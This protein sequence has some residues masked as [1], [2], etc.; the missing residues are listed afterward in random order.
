MH[1]P[2][3]LAI[4]DQ[5]LGHLRADPPESLAVHLQARRFQQ[6]GPLVRID[7]TADLADVRQQDEYFTSRMRDVLSARSMARPMRRKCQASPRDMVDSATPS[8]RGRQLD[9]LEELEGRGPA[10]RVALGVRII[11]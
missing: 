11:R 2:G 5:K 10:A 4:E 3:K 1:G 6:R 7:R 8:N 9:S